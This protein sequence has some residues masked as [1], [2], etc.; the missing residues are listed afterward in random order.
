M[1]LPG[2]GGKCGN[3]DG[4]PAAVWDM[5]ACVGGDGAIYYCLFAAG[6]S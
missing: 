6:Q 3:A 2:A 5:A 4:N 1:D